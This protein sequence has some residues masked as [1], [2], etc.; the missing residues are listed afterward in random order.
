MKEAASIP[1]AKYENN[2]PIDPKRL[3]YTSKNIQTPLKDLLVH[4]LIPHEFLHQIRK[5]AIRVHK[6]SCRTDE[7]VRNVS[8]TSE[9]A[10]LENPIRRVHPVRHL[11]RE[12]QHAGVV[13]GNRSN[14]GH[15]DRFLE[16]LVHILHVFYSGIGVC[17]IVMHSEIIGGFPG[18]VIHEVCNPRLSFRAVGARGT[19]EFLSF[20][21]KGNHMAAP[22]V[23][24]MRRR[25][26]GEL[27]L[28]EKVDDRLI[29]FLD[30]LPVLSGELG[31]QVDHGAERSA[32]LEFRRRPC[33]PIANRAYWALEVD[34]VHRPR[35]T[36]VALAVGIGPIP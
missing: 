22:Q 27:G 33:V 12:R 14:L 34:F 9:K 3:P 13:L 16:L 18:N 35:N 31:F 28:V 5:A 7:P 23:C 36:R 21:A 24:G 2:N 30:P 4:G 1:T 25:D 20:L 29:R 32:T 11:D 15:N 19:D 6:L 10:I 8:H 17:T 26:T